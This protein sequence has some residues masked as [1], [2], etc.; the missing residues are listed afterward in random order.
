MRM[1]LGNR[2]SGCDKKPGETYGLIVAN[3]G[4]PTGPQFDDGNAPKE[5]FA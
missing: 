5:A 3:G 2:L 1:I 4:V